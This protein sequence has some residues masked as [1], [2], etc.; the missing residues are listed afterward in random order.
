M[1]STLTVN[2]KGRMARSLIINLTCSSISTWIGITRIICKAT[3]NLREGTLTSKS[4]KFDTC[5]IKIVIK[6]THFTFVFFTA[7]AYTEVMT[8]ARG[9]DLNIINSCYFFY[10]NLHSHHAKFTFFLSLSFW[11]KLTSSLTFSHRGLNGS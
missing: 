6:M 8:K 10:A 2:T 11:I 9:V 3:I 4:N 5:I 1:F 7:K